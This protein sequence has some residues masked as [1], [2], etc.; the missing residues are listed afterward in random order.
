MNKIFAFSIIILF[1]LLIH[2]CNPIDHIEGKLPEYP[3]I[4]GSSSTVALHKAIR[5][6]L[7]NGE[8][9]PIYHSQTYAALERLVPGNEDPADVI[10]AVRYYDETIL[11]VKNRGAD[12]IIAPIA[13]EG[14]V[15]ITH[16][17]NPINSL[18]QNQL[19]NI[20][21][22]KIV[23]WKEVGGND[24]E[25]IA[26]TRNWDSGSET[27]MKDFMDGIP[28]MIGE[29]PN[30]VLGSMGSMLT[31]VNFTGSA[32]IGYNIYSWTMMEYMIKEEF[33][34]FILVDGIMP[35]N[36]TLADNSY[37]L[38]VYT[39]SYYNKGNSKGKALT[40]WLLTL[41]GQ[42]IVASAGYVGIYG[43]LPVNHGF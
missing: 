34:K 22:G 36:E 6:Y 38:L 35:S 25:I 40:D 13:K 28:V 43:E 23:N 1:V 20:Y 33:I 5:N 26:F 14:F 9:T 15:F 16:P 17:D 39:Y 37:P 42:R 41:T 11:D 31:A 27:A 32:A 12:L 21:S 8:D 4:D 10:L 24:E 19:R 30:R 2:G 7:T 29:D 3:V 18:T